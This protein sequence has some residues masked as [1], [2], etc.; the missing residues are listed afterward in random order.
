M[1]ENMKKNT[2]KFSFYL[3][4]FSFLA[5]LLSFLSRV[6]LAR[7]MDSLAMSYYTILSPTIVILISIVQMGI[8]SVLSKLVADKNY[9]FKIFSTSVYFT[10][11]TT[12]LTTLI[13]LLFIPFL[14]HLLFKES[15]SSLFYCVLPFLPLVALSGLL[16]GY[17]MGKQRFLSSSFSQ[18]FE[19]IARIV[20]LLIAF[21]MV[22]DMTSV[23]M[24]KIAT[25]SI[26]VGEIFSCLFMF[27]CVFLEKKRIFKKMVYSKE[28]LKTILHIAIPMSGSRFIGSFC[29]FLEPILMGMSLSFLQSKQMM[30]SYGT[31][32]GYV[33]PLLTMPSFVTITL[34]NYLLPS[35]TYHYSRN[36]K[37]HANTL[38]MQITLFCLLI[39]I[40]YAILLFF[41]SDQICM[42]F[43]KNTVGS[44]YLKA[45]SIP[46]ILFS[47]QPIF[48]IMLHALDKS[49]ESTIDT[50][51][52]CLFRLAI[53]CFLSQTLLEDAL[54]LALN[55]G[56][57]VTTILHFIRL[58]II[59]KKS[60]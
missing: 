44:Y 59:K 21:L 51:V 29:Y 35:F 7:Q 10:M 56:M 52:G 11:I 38:F 50:L 34:S 48:G 54:I 3:L 20:F 41:Y 46:F 4:F 9:E 22:D 53:V 16:K 26:S 57:I 13:Y 55:I 40:A 23:N 39:G 6:V 17:L 33:L 47:L 60:S 24:A 2:I 49:K 43:Y 32:N 30:L 37:K 28:S 42:L 19:E 14:T 27:I 45:C 15:I 25:L 58:L 12:S 1:G 5:K 18:I 31:L 36:N 8:P